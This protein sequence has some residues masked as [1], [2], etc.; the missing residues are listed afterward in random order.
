MANLKFFNCV[1]ILESDEDTY[2][3]DENEN[4]DEDEDEDENADENKGEYEDSD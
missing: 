4:E 1:E 2:F 3:E